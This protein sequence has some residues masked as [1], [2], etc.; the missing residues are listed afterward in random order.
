MTQ[1]LKSDR[2]FGY[3]ALI[4]VASVFLTPWIVGVPET[5]FGGIMFAC[6]V[7]GSVLVGFCL[8][9][10]G[11]FVGDIPNRVCAGIALII[12]VCTILALVYLS[13]FDPSAW[14]R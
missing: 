4:C 14:R 2:W 8:S 3:G 5:T 9:L 6:F 13:Y 7:W 11:V 1:F 12:F 10:R